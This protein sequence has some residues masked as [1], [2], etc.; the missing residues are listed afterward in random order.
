MPNFSPT[1]P[2][3]DPSD[4]PPVFNPYHHMY[5]SNGYVY[6]PPPREPFSPISEP[7]LIMFLTNETGPSN[8][9]N[10][11]G[12]RPGEIGAGDRASESAYWFNA[13]S[14][15]LGCDNEG[16]DDCTMQISGYVWQSGTQDDVLAFR[17]NISLPACPDYQN[18]KLQQVEFNKNMVGLSGIQI[19]AFVKDEQ[20]MW[21]MDDLAMGWYN[22][23]C[24]AG[25]LR[26]MSR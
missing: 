5:F 12:Q 20:R 21:F 10:A 13:Y 4:A 18:C 3:V 24:E 23:T 7:R 25:L 17:Q 1:D 19:Q 26:M 6:L 9:P 22:N 11:G 16:P 8:N 2:I 14:A 15:Y